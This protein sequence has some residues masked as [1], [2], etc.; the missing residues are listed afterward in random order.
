[1]S[2][3]TQTAPGAAPRADVRLTK[4]AVALW[5]LAPLLL[6]LSSVRPTFTRSDRAAQVP[7]Q[8]GPF[9]LKL[10]REITPN[11][12]R[13][14]GTRDVAWWE[15]DD[16]AGN[17]I[18]L[19]A[20]FHDSNWKSLHPPHIC[21]RGSGFNISVDEDFRLD[22]G[23]GRETTV[24]RLLANVQNQPDRN[25]VSFYAFVGQDFITPSYAGFYLEHAIPALFRQATPGFL[26]RVEAFVGE[27]GLEATQDRCLDM[28]R[29]F[30][31]VGEGLIRP[32]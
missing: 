12:E 14:L 10:E 2:E 21:I 3:H 18:Y 16:Q 28:F 20:V 9:S 7:R 30:L 24:G 27:D 19:T 5:V 4:S 25:Y 1:M 6:F 22:L 23:E 15:F 29:R 31:P 11:I 17:V 13:L 26:V 32:R 8:I